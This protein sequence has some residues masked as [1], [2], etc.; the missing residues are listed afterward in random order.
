MADSPRFLKKRKLQI[1]ADTCR[2][3]QIAR[4]GPAVPAL[5][6]NLRAGSI[7]RPGP[8]FA[9]FILWPLAEPEQLRSPPASTRGRAGA[10][11]AGTSAALESSS[12]IPRPLSPWPISKNRRVSAADMAYYHC[13]MG[14]QEQKDTK[15]RPVARRKFRLATHRCFPPPRSS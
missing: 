8:V 2:C 12:L 14:I 10:V 1:L 9:G 4:D 11:P 5:N 13:F 6:R 3:L 15:N 7:W